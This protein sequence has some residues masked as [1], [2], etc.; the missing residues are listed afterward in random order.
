MPD[1]MTA[2]ELTAY[3]A[4][5]RPVRRP[6]PEP[7]PGEVLVRIAAAPI[8]PS[9]LA[10]LVGAY[11]GRG[12]LPRIPG[13]EGSGTVVAA[14][15]GL[16]PRL[17]LGNNVALS[18]PQGRDGTWAQ[19]TLT[20]ANLTIPLRA[21]PLERGATAIVNPMT[22]WALFDIAR[23]GRHRAIANSAAASALGR[24]VLRLGRRFGLPVVHIVRRPEQVELLRSLGAEHILDSSSADFDDALRDRFRRLDVTLAFDAVAGELS[25]RLLTALPTGGRVLVYGAMSREGSRAEASHLIFEGKRLEGFWLPRWL[26]RKHPLAALRI[27]GRVRAL[28][29]SDLSSAIRERVPLAGVEGALER[30][31]SDMTEGKILLVPNGGGDGGAA[32]PQT[33]TGNPAQVG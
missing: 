5:L 23:R 14:G 27:A 21:V 19:Y 29:T 6:I 11:A 20:Q 25:T 26:G 17:R 28:L 1:T 13:L 2:L 16:L 3:G 18:I 22:A 9:D 15:P 7:G 8:N 31:R 4:P 10:S 24:M 30:Y 12:D 32:T 33:P